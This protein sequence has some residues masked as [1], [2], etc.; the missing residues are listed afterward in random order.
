[1]DDYTLRQATEIAETFPVLIGKPGV[2]P[3]D[4][5]KLY[6]FLPF[7]SD[8]ATHCI[9]FMLCVVWGSRREG[10]EFNLRRAWGTWD[11]SQQRAWKTWAANP[12]FL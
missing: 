12:V 1:M 2:R 6:D 7:A 10:L 9:T 11:L 3:F 8:S 5:Q 4:P